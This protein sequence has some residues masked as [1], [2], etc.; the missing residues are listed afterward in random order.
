MY[1]CVREGVSAWRGGAYEEG[2]R[3][4]DIEQHSTDEHS[5]AQ[6]SSRIAKGAVPAGHVVL[7][8]C[9][10]GHVD[11]VNPNGAELHRE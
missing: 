3:A 11:G 7:L 2:A 1:V 6:R 10:F 8:V 4:H 5:V 9:L